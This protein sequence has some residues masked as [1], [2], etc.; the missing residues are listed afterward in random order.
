VCSDIFTASKEVLI[1]DR[2][3]VERVS[4]TATRERRAQALP[5]RPTKTGVIA[6]KKSRIAGLAT[7]APCG[8]GVLIPAAD[9]AA[10]P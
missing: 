5:I 10:T 7:C 9:F 2:R 3:W 1:S 8:L 4:T 6:H